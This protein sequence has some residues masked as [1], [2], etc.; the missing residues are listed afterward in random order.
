M[1]QS[2]R[3]NPQILKDEIPEFLRSEGLGLFPVDPA[4]WPAQQAIWWDTRR[5]PDYRAFL[6]TAQSVNSRLILFFEEELT[7]ERLEQAEDLL[8]G[9]SEDPVEYREYARRLG[10]IRSHLGFTGRVG[11]GFSHGGSLYWFEVEAPWYEQLQELEEELQLAGTGLGPDF[12]LDDPDDED[13]DPPMG[14][15]YSRN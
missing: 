3:P 4:L 5:Q 8:E 12:D 2:V 7:E 13:E 10:Q 6:A 11:I 15:F 9:V 1:A 14:N